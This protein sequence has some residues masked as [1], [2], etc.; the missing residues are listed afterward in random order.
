MANECPAYPDE[1][2]RVNLDLMPHDTALWM[3]IL[4]A[5]AL[6]IFL[7]GVWEMVHV[8]RLGKAWKPG[9]WKVGLKRL[10]NGLATHRKFMQDRAPGTMHAWIFYGFVVLFIGTLIVAVDADF[11][12]Y[13]LKEKLL[14]GKPYLAYEFILDAFGIVF[15]VGVGYA[16]WRRYGGD[17]PPHLHKTVN[18]E[19][20]RWLPG[21]GD[22]YALAFLGLI[23]ITGFMME[24]IRLQHQ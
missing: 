2:C 14:Y 15:L 10:V 11:F 12:E 9:D 8:W 21:G 19:K 5:V 18:H 13:I 1:P 20:P 22:L 17:R 3:Y 7:Y 24:G 4:T 16:M 6:G 23:G